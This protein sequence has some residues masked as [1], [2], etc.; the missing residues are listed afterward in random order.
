MHLDP[1]YNEHMDKSS[2]RCQ[3]S[4]SY[5]N[6]PMESFKFK[7]RRFQYFFYSCN[8][9]WLQRYCSI[10]KLCKGII[11]KLIN[12]FNNKFFLEIPS[13][14]VNKDWRI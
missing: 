9:D 7:I 2:H 6:R 14:I 12:R 11:P 4:W 1:V 13:F 8:R 3:N 5:K 10:H